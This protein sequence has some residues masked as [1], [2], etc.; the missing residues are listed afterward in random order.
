MW[1]RSQNAVGMAFA[2]AAWSRE[3]SNLPIS[4]FGMPYL[5]TEAARAVTT[6]PVVGSV[7]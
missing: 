6:E 7:S 4:E 5:R 3:I 1:V 2:V